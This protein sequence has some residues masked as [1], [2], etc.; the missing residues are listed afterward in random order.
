MLF[1]Y[2]FIAIHLKHAHRMS[3]RTFYLHV[4]YLLSSNYIHICN[5]NITG[6]FCKWHPNHGIIHLMFDR[7]NIFMSAFLNLCLHLF[8][9][10]LIYL[11]NGD[12]S[13]K[14]GSR[15]EIKL[16][17]IKGKMAEKS[18]IKCFINKKK[19][20]LHWHREWCNACV[21]YSQLLLPGGK[22]AHRK[23][24][25]DSITCPFFTLVKSQLK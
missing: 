23:Q 1:Y 5:C 22:M 24:H 14:N 11:N 9:L 10:I 18:M 21:G 15:R 16:K 25:F 13:R 8:Y 17:A 3:W 6:K 4:I 2:C 7:L 19:S 20:T 12:Q